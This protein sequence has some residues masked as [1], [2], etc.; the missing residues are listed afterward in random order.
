MGSQRY[1]MLI[2][3]LFYLYFDIE[4]IRSLNMVLKELEQLPSEFIGRYHL[5]NWNNSKLK[6]SET[7]RNFQQINIIVAHH[8][9]NVHDANVD[10]FDEE[11]VH[12]TGNGKRTLTLPHLERFHGDDGIVQHPTNVKHLLSL[13]VFEKIY[14]YYGSTCC[15]KL[16]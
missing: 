8:Q 1:N 7:I 3:K 16:T 11:N 2:R 4:E 13:L 6:N 12:L 14:S 10:D 15:V 5:D 9:D